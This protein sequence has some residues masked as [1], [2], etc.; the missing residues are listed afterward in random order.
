MTLRV[1]L[2][3]YLLRNDLTVEERNDLIVHIMDVL[4][5]I[6]LED[7]VYTNEEGVLMVSGKEVGLEKARQLREHARAALDNKA[8]SLIR[9]Q[10]RYEA[11]IQAGVKAP[12]TLD[13][14]FY[15]A[16]LWWGTKEEEKLN[17][18]AQRGVVETQEI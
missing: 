15:R 17:V 18:L 8:L 3:K 7:I 6:P 4:Q 11:F 10:V 12:N 5:A 2:A 14:L 13:L 16:A 1:K 9:E